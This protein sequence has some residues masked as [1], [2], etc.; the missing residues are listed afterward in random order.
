MADNADKPAIASNGAIEVSEADKAKARKWFR[1]AHES[2]DKRDYD[3]AIQSFIE[4]LRFWPEAVEEGHMPLWAVGIARQQSGGKKPG[5]MDSMKLSMGGKDALKAMLNAETL[6]AKD[7]LNAGYIDNLLKNAVRGGYLETARWIAPKVLESLK[8]DKKPNTGRFKAF[9]QATVQAA[10]QADSNSD[11]QT[12]AFFYEQAVVS[13]DFLVARNP[14]DMALK[15]EQREFSGRLTIAKGKY[16]DAGSFRDSIQDSESQKALQD[17]ERVQQGDQTLD[18]LIVSTK[19]EWEANPGIPAK[20]FNYVDALLRRERKAEEDEAIRVLMGAFEESRTYNFKKKADDIRLRQIRRAARLWHEKASQSRKPDDIQKAKLAAQQYVD[21]EIAVWRDRVR[22]YPTDLQMKFYFGRA[23]FQAK[24]FDDAIPV[25]QEAQG[26]ARHRIRAMSL[27]GR[28]FY[29]KED[30]LTASD[31][32]RDAIG[33]H[34]TPQDDLGKELMYWLGRSY[35]EEGKVDDAKAQYS[36]LARMDYNY[37][38]GDARQRLDALKK[39][40]A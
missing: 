30:F 5:M 19:A 6:L 8:R 4:G 12:A 38:G 16:A 37:A 18:A 15:D 39:Q 3:Y 35:E 33:L 13:L 9:R 27:L 20:L 1:H 11:P 22:N 2:R 14:T 40:G 36:K 26:D 31:V 21:T 23:L 28:S 10:E 17:A 25:L 32:L 24:Q 7:P 34:E 29:E